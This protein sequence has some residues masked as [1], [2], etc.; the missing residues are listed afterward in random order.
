VGQIEVRAGLPAL[1][2]E[3]DGYIEWSS[4]RG[5]ARGLSAGFNRQPDAEW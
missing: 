3:G 2:D 4:K 5:G 1:S